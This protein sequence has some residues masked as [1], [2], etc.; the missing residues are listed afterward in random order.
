MFDR[1][2]RFFRLLGFRKTDDLLI[3][4]KKSIELECFDNIKNFLIGYGLFLDFADTNKQY[5]GDFDKFFKDAIVMISDKNSIKHKFGRYY[6]EFDVTMSNSVVI[7][8]EKIKNLLTLGFVHFKEKFVDYDKQHEIWNE[9]IDI[10]KI[11]SIT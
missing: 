10:E 6:I 4:F 5:T 8:A 7:N 9:K 2:Y 3:Y 11:R 1:I